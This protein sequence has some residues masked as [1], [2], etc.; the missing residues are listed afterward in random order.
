MRVHGEDSPRPRQRRPSEDHPGDLRRVPPGDLDVAPFGEQYL[1][2]LRLDLEWAD[3]AASDSLVILDEVQESPWAVEI[4]LTTRP[5]TADMA[6]LS[7]SADLIGADRR[8][9]L[10][11]RPGF[12]QS[13]NRAMSDL[14]GMVA[15]AIEDM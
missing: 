13:G 9:L 10:T 1:L 2:R 14:A 4:K 7:E 8:F 3:V 11:R 15:T 12:T 5:R 6:R